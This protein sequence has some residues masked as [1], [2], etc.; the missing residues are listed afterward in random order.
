MRK[1]MPRT[2]RSNR[3]K[4]GETYTI[5]REAEDGLQKKYLQK[6]EIRIL[7]KYR[8]GFALCDMGNGI[9]ECFS[10]WELNRIVVKR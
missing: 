8:Y 5:Q 1:Q 6:K 7:K 10:F 9:R 3:F 4:T 2:N